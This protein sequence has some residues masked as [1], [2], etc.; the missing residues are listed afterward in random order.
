MESLN[1]AFAIAQ[2]TEKILISNNPDF[3]YS[4]TRKMNFGSETAQL[5]FLKGNNNFASIQFKKIPSDE[6]NSSFEIKMLNSAGDTK[7][8]KLII[9]DAEYPIRVQASKIAKWGEPL[10]NLDP[11]PSLEKPGNPE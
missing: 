10:L 8:L 9:V 2:Q 4:V 5:I 1:T 3:P 6:H 7:L 11:S